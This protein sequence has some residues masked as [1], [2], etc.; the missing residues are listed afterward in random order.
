M[1]N[2]RHMNTTTCTV[3]QPNLGANLK[4]GGYGTVA[5]SE[6]NRRE[7]HMQCSQV[8]GWDTDNCCES[9]HE[10][11]DRYGIEGFYVIVVGELLHMCCRAAESV[12]WKGDI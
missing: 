2:Q 5:S 7:A 10:D 1:D 4:G 9:C 6:Q 8:P 12:P 3:R 11:W